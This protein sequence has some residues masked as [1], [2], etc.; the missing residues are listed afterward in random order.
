MGVMT[1]PA[2]DSLQE[3]IV[4]LDQRIQAVDEA[5]WLSSRYAAVETR[6]SLIVLYAFYYEL[7]RV[8]LAVSDQTL[9]NI[10]FQWWRDAFAELARGETRQHD[11]VLTLADQIGR[12]HLHAAPLISLIDAHEAA[13]LA[14]DRSL[15][16]E[17]ALM[18]VAA[19]V[20]AK[21]DRI[22]GVLEKIAAEWAGVRR[23][24]AVE[25]LQP[26]FQV[27][28]PIRPAI[29]HFRLRRLWARTPT[30]SALQK[31]ASVFM[32]MLTGQV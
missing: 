7:A 5:R 18:R 1:S 27:A 13:F 24:D 15:E 26:R 25:T 12:G 8:R 32:A 11:V 4:R 19:N 28:A 2:S 22:A 16:P 20:C 9:G 30:P 6:T 10:R 21:T 3:I 29:G 14:N 17:A 23:G 31:R